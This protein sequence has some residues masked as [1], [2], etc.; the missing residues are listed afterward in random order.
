MKYKSLLRKFVE[1]T[2]QLESR[3]RNLIVNDNELW[4][5][6][7]VSRSDCFSEGCSM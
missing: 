1:L 4:K 6:L 2:G 5:W 7:R 3:F